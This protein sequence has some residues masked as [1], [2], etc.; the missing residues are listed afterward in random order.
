MA[1]VDTEYGP[2]IIV[3]MMFSFDSYAHDNRPKWASRF[4][5]Q[6]IVGGKF[7]LYGKII[8]IL[9]GQVQR[10]LNRRKT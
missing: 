3:R 1:E 6:I 8:V 9:Q 10:A 5:E 2:S 4:S 7:F